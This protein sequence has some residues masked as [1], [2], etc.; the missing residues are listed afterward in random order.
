MSEVKQLPDSEGWWL[1]EGSDH[2][3]HV[4]AKD[5]EFKQ[6]SSEI[7]WTLL[8]GRWLKVQ[9]PVFPPLKELHRCE[10]Q[11]C[12]VRNANSANGTVYLATKFADSLWLHVSWS[13]HPIH[14]AYQV[15]ELTKSE[16]QAEG[17]RWPL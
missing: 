4:V 5:G 7:W 6:Y 16:C 12:V 14:H 17:Y 11:E 2:P 3:S 8:P 9:L 1:K 13:R 15:T 10:G